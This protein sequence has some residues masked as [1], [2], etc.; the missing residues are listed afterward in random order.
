[1]FDEDEID[2]SFNSLIIDAEASRFPDG[3]LRTSTCLLSE[4]SAAAPLTAFVSL[5]PFQQARLDRRFSM[6]GLAF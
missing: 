1:V 6:S 5:I 2:R 4:Q 3:A